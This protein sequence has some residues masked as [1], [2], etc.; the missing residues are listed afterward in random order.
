MSVKVSNLVYNY[1][2]SKYA[3]LNGV[4]FEINKG[5]LLV[6]LGNNGCGKTTLINN[7]VGL[8]K[9]RSGSIEVD[10]INLLSLNIHKRSKYIS[11]VSQKVNSLEDVIIFD[12]LTFGFANDIKFYDKPNKKQI[13]KVKEYA[14]KLKITHLLDKKIDEISGGER[15]IVS[16][17][18]ALLQ[19][20]EVIVL[21]EPTSALDLNNQNMVLSTLKDIV[22]KE[23]KT[24]ILST[25]NPNHALYLDSRVAV[26]KNGYIIEYGDCKDVIKVDKLK[27]IYGDNLCYSNELEYKEVSFKNK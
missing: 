2:H 8:A 1:P 24:M 4:N 20:S 7:I 18:C 21:D 9:P 26:M 11:Y 22:K 16:I 13:N 17:C 12:Y 6:L 27:T 3:V 25:H 15:Q 23:N 14:E 5:D 19:N 10:G